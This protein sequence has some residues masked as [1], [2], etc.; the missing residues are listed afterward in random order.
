MRTLN[1]RFL[2][3]F[4][5]IGALDARAAS[6]QLLSN[7]LSTGGTTSTLSACPVSSLATSSKVD[8][9]LRQ[10][11]V[12]GDTR[13]RQVIVSAAGG[14]LGS[15]VTLVAGLGSTV[16][17]TLPGINAAVA[18]VDL[19]DLAALACALPVSSISL[20][21]VVRAAG[22]VESAP[23]PATLRAT[24]GLPRDT[25][26][27]T[28]VTVAVIDS[29]IARSADFANRIVAFFDVTRGLLPT[30]PS[31]AYGH[32][33][34]VA[35]LIAGTGM[36]SGDGRYQ[37]VGP[38]VRLVGMK[39]LDANGAGRTSDVIRAVELTTLL[40]PVLGV[41]IMNLSLGHPI[42]EPAASDPLVRAVEAASRAGIIVVAAAGNYGM[43]SQTRRGRLRRHRVARQRPVGD[44]RR[45]A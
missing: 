37:G 30:T 15:V 17:G 29:G 20:D 32:G 16:L 43:N 42:Y 5:L 10:W 2:V 4:L 21:A 3:C 8:A 44:H 13:P 45:I 6:A 12:S 25:P 7:L 33:T 31:D 19:P 35:G 26:A 41:Q 39:V 34:H 28:G 22:Q 9:A 11:A 24:L 27:G 38:Q 36:L 1:R 23:A 40:K 18:R 14:A